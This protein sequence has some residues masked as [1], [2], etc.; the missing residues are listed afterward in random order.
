MM[1]GTM[2]RM[3]SYREIIQENIDYDV[4]VHDNPQDQ[5]LLDGYVELMAETCCSRGGFVRI[6][7]T[8]MPVEVVKSRLLKLTREHIS[9]VVTCM[10]GVTTQIRNIRAYMLSSLYNAPTT[11]DQYYSSLVSYHSVATSG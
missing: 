9:Y 1:E 5:E 7:R 6:N 11:I 4:M 8:N 2:D 3:D 10:K